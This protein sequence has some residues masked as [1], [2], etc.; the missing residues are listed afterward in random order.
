MLSVV[1]PAGQDLRRSTIPGSVKWSPS[2]TS[3][4]P[5]RRAAIIS[6]YSS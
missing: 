6:G 2:P 1:G 3:G 4:A 5:G